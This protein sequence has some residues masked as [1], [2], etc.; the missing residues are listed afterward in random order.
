[1]PRAKQNLVLRIIL[2]EEAGQILFQI[3]FVAM[4]RLQDAH[5]RLKGARA[6]VRPGLGRAPA[7]L[8]HGRRDHQAVD[9]R[10]RHSQDGKRAERDEKNVLQCH[11]VIDLGAPSRD[12]SSRKV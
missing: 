11:G 2:L 9:G 3:R 1:V 6:P 7:E 10:G 4:Q 5:R 8:R 12:C